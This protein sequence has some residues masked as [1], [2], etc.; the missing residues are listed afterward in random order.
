[1]V[2]PQAINSVTHDKVGL[3]SLIFFE[4]DWYNERAKRVPRRKRR[5]ALL[6]VAAGLGAAPHL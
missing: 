2:D 3:G 6:T 5:W 4:S 1:M